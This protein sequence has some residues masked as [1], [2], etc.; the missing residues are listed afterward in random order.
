MSENKE[1][2]SFDAMF[3]QF[4]TGE[5]EAEPIPSPPKTEK[6]VIQPEEDKKPRENK[7]RQEFEEFKRFVHN[8]LEELTLPKPEQQK[9]KVSDNIKEAWNVLYNS[10]FKRLGGHLPIGDKGRKES[11]LAHLE[12]V[13]KF[14]KGQ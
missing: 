1:F 13:N 3:D 5:K 12:M 14:F 2:D 9:V 11:L 6:K 10:N 4:G 7:L 8:R